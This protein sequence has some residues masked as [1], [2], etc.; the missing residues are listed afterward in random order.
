MKKMSRLYVL[1][2][3]CLHMYLP[4]SSDILCEEDRIDRLLPFLG[5]PCFVWRKRM[6]YLDVRVLDLC[7]VRVCLIL[8]GS[9][10]N[11]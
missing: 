9:P 10:N 4:D 2:G 1:F 7:G 3:L 11:G 6:P 5:A 8:P